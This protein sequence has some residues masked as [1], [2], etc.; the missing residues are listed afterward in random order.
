MWFQRAF[1]KGLAGRTPI[2]AAPLDP[3]ML[4]EQGEVEAF[5]DAIGLRPP[6]ARGAMGNILK[7]Q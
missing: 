7:L 2:H 1:S 4:I 3:E 6:H 5:K